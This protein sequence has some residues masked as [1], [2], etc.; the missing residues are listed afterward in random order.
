[1]KTAILCMF[2][3]FAE[4]QSRDAQIQQLARRPLPLPLP[5]AGA[6]IW[7]VSYQTSLVM[8]RSL[9]G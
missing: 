3:N 7:E 8:L 4:G 9:M 1:M 5:A 6:M 2:Y